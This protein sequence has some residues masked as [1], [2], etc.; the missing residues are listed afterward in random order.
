MLGLLAR[1]RA[2]ANRNNKRQECSLIISE[3]T[4]KSLK[5]A[6][7]RMNETALINS[8]KLTPVKIHEYFFDPP[9]ET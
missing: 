1:V 9:S 6:F 3:L 8:F 4:N 5:V 7:F 2:T